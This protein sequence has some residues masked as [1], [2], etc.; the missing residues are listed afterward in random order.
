MMRDNYLMGGICLGLILVA[1][2]AFVGV[3]E[4]CDDDRVS[5]GSARWE[6][7]Q[8]LHEARRQN[9]LLEEQNRLIRKA[10]RHARRLEE[11]ARVRQARESYRQA[12]ERH[13]R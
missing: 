13:W 8:T 11:Q 1:L 2:P 12:I 7:R 3:A 5:Y 9:R 6:Q 10:N 4:A